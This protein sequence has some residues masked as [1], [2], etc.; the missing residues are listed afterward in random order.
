[1][2]VATPYRFVRCQV[3]PAFADVQGW[4]LEVHGNDRQLIVALHKSIV[5]KYYSI[6][7]QDS[8]GSGGDAIQLATTWLQSLKSELHRALCWSIRPAVSSPSVT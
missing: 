6:L 1:M 3:H 8:H 5:A 7:G 2:T 4:F